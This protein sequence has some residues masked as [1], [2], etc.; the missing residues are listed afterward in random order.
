ADGPAE[1]A[2]LA[3]G[4]QLLAVAGLKLTAGNWAH[5]MGTL[6]PGAAVKLAYFR[7]DELL[8]ATITPVAPVADTWTLSLAEVAGEVLA[9]RQA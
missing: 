9:R 8:E 7:G 1:A 6:R 4:A 2:G 3:A 5:R